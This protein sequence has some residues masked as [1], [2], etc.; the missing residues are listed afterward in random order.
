[1]TC[2]RTL[3]CLSVLL[4]GGA[5]L[6]LATGTDGVRAVPSVGAVAPAASRALFE[7]PPGSLFSQPANNCDSWSTANTSGETSSFSYQVFDDFFGVA[8]NICDIHWWGL[9]LQWTGSGWAIG[10]PTGLTFEINFYAGPPPAS[11]VC[12][13]TVTP[14]ATWECQYSGV[15]D[16]WRFDVM[17]LSPC[18]TL[19]DGWVSVRSLLDPEGD[20][21]L[22]LDAGAGNGIQYD[23]TS[24]NP[25]GYNYGFCLTGEYIQTWGACCFDATTDCYDGVEQLECLSAGGRFAANTPCADLQPPCGQILGACCYEDG[26]CC[27]TTMA[28]CGMIGDANCDGVIDFDDINYF[29]AAL[30]GG[31]PCCFTHVDCDR[32]GVI[33]FDDI[34]AFVALISGGPQPVGAMWLGPNTSCDDCP[35]VVHCP[36]GATDEGEPCYT[37][38]NGGCNSTPYVWGWIACGET[39][40]GTSYFDGGTRDTDWFRTDTAVS[41][42]FTMTAEAEFDLQLLFLKDDGA[43]C[44][45]YE[46]WYVTTGPCS[47]ATLATDCFP[48]STYIVWVGPQFTSTFGCTDG[49][50]QYWVHL[51]CVECYIPLGA[52]CKCGECLPNMSEMDCAALGGTWLGEGT[53]CDPNPC[54]DPLQGESCDNPFVVDTLPYDTYGNT[55]SYCDNYDEV[56]PYSGSTSPAVAYMFTPASDVT[57]QISLCN[58]GTAYDTKLYVYEGGCPGNLIACN[59]DLCNT[60]QYPS[61]YVSRLDGV[62]LMGGL[63]YY[64]IVDGYGGDCGDYHL[65]IIEQVSQAGDTCADPLYLSDPLPIDA[66]GETCSFLNN[67]DEVCPFSGATAPDVAYQYIPSADVVVD[68]TLCVSPTDYDSKLFIYEGDCPGTLIGC[69]DDLCQTPE[70][71][72]DY[73]SKIECVP[74]LAGHVYYIIVDGYGTSC[75]NYH[76]QIAECVPCDVTCPGG[77]VPEAEPCGSDTNGG[78]N[79]ATPV[80]EP[81]Y[82]NETICGTAWFDGSTRDTDWYELV[83]TDSA[84]VTVTGI[85][86]FKAI[87]GWI[88]QYTPGVPGC[89]NITGNF[90]QYVQVD[91]CVEGSF[92]TECWAPGT[93]YIWAGPQFVNPIYCGTGD[94]Y[95]LT[96]TCQ[97]CA[98]PTGAC[99]VMGTCIGDMTAPECGNQG[100]TWFQGESCSYF[101][102]PVPPANDTC[103]T[104]EAITEPYPVTVYGTCIGSTVDCPGVLD[105]NAVWYKVYLPNANNKLSVTYCG[106]TVGIGTVGIVYYN[107]CDD[108]PNY[109]IVTS[110]LWNTCSPGGDYGIDMWWDNVPGPGDVYVPAYLVDAGG[111]PMD[112]YAT[113]NVTA[114]APGPVTSKNP[115]ATN[116]TASQLQ[117]AKPAP[118]VAR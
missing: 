95:V 112:F 6:A 83:L 98:P 29:V 84:Y 48:P 1:M 100:G 99:C 90:L 15:Y 39:I 75:G 22:W 18:C 33:D 27:Q 20:V 82:C 89:S 13:Y 93:Y 36:P 104:A 107:M 55:C 9:V 44:A 47:V 65:T 61:S 37:D 110:Y 76:L 14:T 91:K 80:F 5:A 115:P 21:F 4:I 116:S 118:K 85:A 117:L 73:V 56:C 87:F 77:A 111:L 17:S 79:M 94:E 34:N 46:Y 109:V 19:T 78:C 57:V 43:D 71:P 69:N 88:E 103:A 108:C 7:C 53:V 12:T 102:C 49:N 72:I 52:C 23:G 54:G 81:A 42:Y 30:S 101:V 74:L 50:T 70:F 3:C 45:G 24:Y 40:C 35:C 97:P 28:G 106:A 60:P 10:D 8:G 26:W 16:F 32:N 67:Y 92:T 63:T 31:T 105:W 51:D 113:F 2:K 11:P 41:Y 66:F 68:V 38:T 62:F 59:D 58:D 96:I 64:I 25:T 86:E 114:M